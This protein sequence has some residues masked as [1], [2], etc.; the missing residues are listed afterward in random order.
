MTDR[1]R[2]LKHENSR[3]RYAI[4]AY[5]KTKQ[6]LLKSLTD[7]RA[8]RDELREAWIYDQMRQGKAGNRE[9]AIFHIEAIIR[10]LSD[11]KELE[12]H[13]ESD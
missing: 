6:G 12:A 4:K 2:D 8:D 3:L 11:S 7:I 13:D 5:E 10:H 9:S 1:E